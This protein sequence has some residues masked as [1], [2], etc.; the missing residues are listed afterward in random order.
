M[1]NRASVA[2]MRE[3]VSRSS[4]TNAALRAQGQRYAQHVLEA[5][6][7][8]EKGPSFNAFC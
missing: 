2:E 4:P 8:A 3:L 7:N 1:L 6:A 5:C